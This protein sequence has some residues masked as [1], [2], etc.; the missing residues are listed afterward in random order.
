M[1]ED[2]PW[3]DDRDPMVRLAEAR[4]HV[5]GPRERESLGQRDQCSES[6]AI[7]PGASRSSTPTPRFSDESV[8][9]DAGPP[10]LLRAARRHRARYVQNK[11]G[12]SLRSRAECSRVALA[13]GPRAGASA[14]STYFLRRVGSGSSDGA[15]PHSW[16]ARVAVPRTRA[17]MDDAMA[18]PDHLVEVTRLEGA[19]RPTTGVRLRES[20]CRRGDEATRCKLRAVEPAAGTSSALLTHEYSRAGPR[21]VEGIGA[22]RC[23]C[24][25]A[26]GA[27]RLASALNAH[28]PSCDRL[29]MSFEQASIWPTSTKP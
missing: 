16:P 4:G 7:S 23:R 10:A 20:L 3:V 15:R 8:R 27:M 25:R 14:G 21:A 6:D 12:R 17:L 28:R 19:M 26:T 13:A 2:T 5:A 1:R 22:S 29:A 9:D 11:H 18:L 24:A